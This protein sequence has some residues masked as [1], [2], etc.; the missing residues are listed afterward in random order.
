MYASEIW[1]GIASDNGLS[2]SVAMQLP[3]CK[4]ENWEQASVIFNG[5][6]NLCGESNLKMRSAHCS[7]V[8]MGATASQITSFMIVHSTV[9]SNA[10]QRKHQRSEWLAFV[11]EPVTGEFPAQRASNAENVSIW[12]RHHENVAVYVQASIGERQA[13]H[14]KFPKILSC[15]PAICPV[16]ISFVLEIKNIQISTQMT[17]NSASNFS[18]IVLYATTSREKSTIEI[19]TDMA[20]NE[21]WL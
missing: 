6:I 3:Y 17:F 15:S 9:Y 16:M 19:S 5:I 2:L 4:A 1:V 18:N 11:R 10:D 7:D 13:C 21:V 20:T 14:K 8:I 12:W